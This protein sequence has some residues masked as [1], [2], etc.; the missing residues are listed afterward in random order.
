MYRKSAAERE[1]QPAGY[2]GGQRALLRTSPNGGRTSIV[3]IEKGTRVQRHRHQA[4]EDVLILAGKIQSGG[5]TLVTGDYFFTD[6]GEEHDLVALEDSV[7]YV[8]SDKPVTILE[9]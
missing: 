3:A 8:S 4:G 2:A 9:K 1:W 6:V 7:I 5:F